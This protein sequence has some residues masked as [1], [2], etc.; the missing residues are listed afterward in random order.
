VNLQNI[1]S[2]IT[3]DESLNN[4]KYVGSVLTHFFKK[5]K[6]LPVLRAELKMPES[7][8][9]CLLHLPNTR[10][11]RELSTPADFLSQ[12]DRRFYRTPRRKLMKSVKL[13]LFIITAFLLC[14]VLSAK[15]QDVRDQNLASG[16]DVILQ[17]NRVL[18]QVIATPGAQPTTILPQRSY[19]MMHLAMFDA[20]NSIDG[21]YTPYL[22]DVPGSRNASTKAAAAQAA[23]DV[24]TVLY[25]NQQAVFEIELANSLIGI[26]PNRARQGIRVGRI[27]AE[28]I[29]AN[30]ANDGWTATPPAYILPTTP[31]NWQPTPPANA[32][33]AFTHFPNVT[34]FA[35]TQATQFLPAPPPALTSAEYAADFN[36]EK[37][38]GSATSAT[39]TADQTLTAQLWASGPASEVRYNNLV[40]SLA[41]SRNNSTVENARLFALYFIASHDALQ[42]SFTSK[43]TFG[44]W[45]PVT[46]IRRADED[47]NPNTVSDPNWTSLIAAPPYPTYAGNAAASSASLATTLALFFGRDDIPF[48]INFGT[49]NVIRNYSSFSALNT[50]VSRSR[51]YGGIHFNFDNA[52]GQSIGRN[53]AHFVFL[54]YLTPRRCNL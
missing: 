25:P 3:A 33:A 36:E 28:R 54:N 16:E 7:K 31:G 27:C 52:A 20:V 45:R 30:R 12:I 37:E 35:L 34:P 13:S 40:R 6:N 46:A 11:S 32:P 51:V 24:L 4:K 49:P 18:G 38:L 43:Y 53:V 41:L 19:A 39:R 1:A 9:F 44:L 50:E 22:T 47:G 29:L 21:S 2:I 23:Y 8:L 26:S 42:S 48:Q 17:W 5:M 10:G 15:A 14:A